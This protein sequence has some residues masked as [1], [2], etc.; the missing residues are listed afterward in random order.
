MP[1]RA[2]HLI[3]FNKSLWILLNLKWIRI[4][5]TIYVFSENSILV[6]SPRVFFFLA[7]S[8][9]VLNQFQLINQGQICHWSICLLT[10]V[11]L[12]FAE[13]VLR[14]WHTNTWQATSRWWYCHKGGTSVW[15]TT[16]CLSLG[17]K[18]RFWIH[19][20]FANSALNREFFNAGL[21]TA[22]AMLI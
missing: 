1:S 11:C 7:L 5:N 20:D 22:F 15:R 2:W 18:E 4:L 21:L 12:R 16:R 13:L 17:R 9:R 3:G 14:G 8:L 19:T 6:Q 10:W